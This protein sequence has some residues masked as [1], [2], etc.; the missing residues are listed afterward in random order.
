MSLSALAPCPTDTAEA[1]RLLDQI[2]ALADVGQFLQAHAVAQQLGD[3]R[4]WRGARATALAVR[5]TSR[6]GAPRLATALAFMGY[7]RHPQA[8][9]TRLTY[10]RFLQGQRGHHRAWRFVQQLGNWLPERA[11]RRAEWL[12][13]KSNL[14]AALRDFDRSAE[15][16]AQVQA[17]GVDDPW[18][19]V[20]RSYS[21]EHEDR[22]AEALAL[23]E[24]V[25]QQHPD[26]RS[27]VLQA[28][29]LEMQLNQPEAAIERLRQAA[30][31][32][33]NAG[34]CGQL[35]EWLIE[36]EQLDEALHWL[37]RGEQLQPL[38]EKQ[39]GAWY[40]ARRCDIACLRGDYPLAHQLTEDVPWPFYQ[41][42]RER[43]AAPVGR[44]LLL[45]VRFVRQH[46]MTCVPAT[47]TALSGFWNRPVAHLEVA[48]EI[49]YDGTSNQ[50]ERAWAERNGWRVAEFTVDWDTSRAL[51]DRGLPFTL[52]LQYTGS[53]HLQAVVGYDEPRGSLLIRD[54][55]QSQFGEC[56]AEGLFASQQPSGPRGMLLLPPEEAHRLDGLQ[57]PDEALWDLYYRL[58]TA[59]EIHQRDEAMGCL[60][61][62]REQ[63]PEHRLTWQAQRA[64][65]WYDGREHQVLEATEA[66]LARF[67]DDANLILSKASSLAQLQSREVQLA[68]LASH[69]Q[70]RWNEPLIT[71]RYA[72]LLSRD[73][74]M[75]AQAQLL[76]ER[77]LRQTPSQAQAWNALASVR[78]SEGLREEA[79][80]LYRLAACLH[81]TQE[82]Y[83]NQYF[84]ALRAL[85]RTDEGMLFLKQR[86]ERLGR[87]DAGPTLTYGEFLE[88][89]QHPYEARA[90]LEQAIA[91]RP[92]DADLMLVLA[93]F[94]GRNGDLPGN[95]HWL[96]QAEPHSRRSSWLKAAVLYSQRSEGDVQQALAWCQEAT[97]RDPLNLS[98]HRM[99]V[100]LLVQTAGDDAADAYVDELT[101]SHPHHLGIAELQ[102][103]RAQ[104][105]S[106]ADTEQ[107][108][109][110]LLTSHPQSAWATRELAIVLAR[111]GKRS[112]AL[113]IGE[114]ARQLDPNESF[115]YST[116]GF[117]L[118]QDGQREAAAE[119]F[120]T[121]VRLSVDNDYACDMLLDI[122]SSQEET[123]QSLD[124]I[125]S[126][127]TRQVTFG[128]GWF[129]YY[130]QAQRLL[131]DATL[132]EQMGEALQ[133]RPDL[134]Q[135]WVAVARQ[136]AALEHFDKAEGVLQGAIERFPLLPRLSL[137][138]AKL[139]KSQ[140]QLDACKATLLES[141]SISPLWTATVSLYID[142]LLEQGDQLPEAERLLRSVL[143][144]SPDDNELR[145][146]LS[147]VLGE[148]EIYVYAA[149]EAERVLRAEP[150]N[151]WAW[152]Q[153]GRYCT[154]LNEP[155]R[156]LNL[157]R[158]LVVRRAGDVDAWLALAEQENEVADKEQALREALRFNPRHRKV[159]DQLLTLLLQ[160]E[161]HD[162]LRELLAAPCWGGSTPVELALFG[163]R[164]LHAQGQLDDAMKALYA[165]LKRDPDSYDGWRQMADW[166]EQAGK[167]NAY[168]N[169]AREM[170]RIQPKD[171]IAHG[172]LGHALLLNGQRGEA[173]PSFSHAFKLDPQYVFGGVNEI[174]LLLEEYSFSRA[175][176]VVDRVLAVNQEAPAWIRAL[177]VAG[178]ARDN[179]L[180]RRAWQALA[181]NA[182]AQEGWSEVIQEV[183]ASDKICQQVLDE[184]IEQATLHA[185]A[186]DTWLRQQDAR[187]W[188]GSLSR[189]INKAL[190]NDPNN[191]AKIAILRLLARR[192]N[193]NAQLHT[194]L[195][196][197]RAAMASDGE[198]WAVVGYA[199]VSHRRYETMFAWMNDWRRADAPAWGL[200][201]LALA[202]RTRARDQEA[203]AVSELALQRDAQNW[204]AMVWL[205]TD[206]AREERLDDLKAWLEKIPGKDL[207]VF[208]QAFVHLLRGY[209]QA[210]EA[211]NSSAA[212]LHFHAARACAKGENHPAFRRLLNSL[213]K[214]LAYSEL[215]PTWR[216]LTRYL[217]LRY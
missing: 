77:A 31:R 55:G 134:W 201:N 39:E 76:L 197:S 41:I 64:L 173:L 112:E 30:G 7:R 24:T 61:H 117:V 124:V 52:S 97:Q 194:V 58:T 90:L 203:A 82:G 83:S 125:H 84:R 75:N 57:L 210:V 79:C 147:Y 195:E 133:Q 141:F 45:P 51:I 9:E 166:H 86:Q 155:Q 87:L 140:G 179:E 189:A 103:E 94:C 192:Q 212:R 25:L 214:R 80:E 159:N 5:L 150:G 132:M 8:A 102:V 213:S 199:L 145:A 29:Q 171:A 204:D 101:V 118:L 180:K 121:A 169:A 104:R 137:E 107:A 162:A 120:R 6:L 187:R 27:A 68:W 185:G 113:E 23:C 67:P 154:A 208:Y 170:V 151:G 144:R 181:S 63:A 123:R 19:S 44:R 186:I 59:L 56:L 70:A 105:R 42:I 182:N 149:D 196:A 2:E 10:G 66:L 202:L 177:R 34:L 172:F 47:L 40:A 4:Q 37:A 211:G 152:N 22:Y 78:W 207:R 35:V 28:A 100:R 198:L 217:Q 38:K 3:Y 99:Y 119:A 115:S 136:H 153:L 72:G 89:L 88:E 176:E 13:L 148:Q 161:R 200:D 138:A 183:P 209:V 53:G 114:Q 17:C 178:K 95:Q 49:C 191:T 16:Y 81:G 111:Q 46:H 175:R 43:L 131:D 110:R 142:C 146:Y 36:A 71:V 205:A 96:Q 109:R 60:Q 20:E 216:R 106:L 93:D 18:L 32:M 160:H 14:Y 158:E 135:L 116:L 163:P 11:D 168:V 184:G 156:P 129:N 108:L 62:L 92:Q 164:S 85:G 174:D 139:Q 65:A 122:G 215:T 1:H 157:A 73:E 69:C 74:R 190:R 167:Y 206:A 193:C 91:V 143:L 130:L 21:L 128:N 12:S 165:L 54:P 26:Y 48:E 15:L 98:L 33:E 188:P 127:L 50:A 126:E